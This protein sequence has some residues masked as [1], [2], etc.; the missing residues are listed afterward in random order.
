VAFRAIGYSNI[1][2]AG[3]KLKLV[4]EENAERVRYDKK[5]WI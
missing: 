2:Q 4:K 5:I 1:N 3:R